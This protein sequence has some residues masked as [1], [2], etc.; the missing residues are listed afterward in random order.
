L[1]A[2]KV[3]KWLKGCLT[4]PAALEARKLRGE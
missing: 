2:P 3:Q 1:K 4:R